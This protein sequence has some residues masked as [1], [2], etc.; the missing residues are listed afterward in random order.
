MY[1]TIQQRPQGIGITPP[2]KSANN[3]SKSQGDF[4]G[5]ATA[6]AVTIKRQTSKEPTRSIQQSPP[7][8]EHPDGFKTISDRTISS[9]PQ[10]RTDSSTAAKND[11]I[12]ANLIEMQVLNSA[13]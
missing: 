10:T 13:H 5:K 11:K 3:A 6:F 4:I 2:E 12:S 1:Y 8:T 9:Y 7:P